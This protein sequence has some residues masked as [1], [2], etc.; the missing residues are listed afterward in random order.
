[1][2]FF[3]NWRV[4][5]ASCNAYTPTMEQHIAKLELEWTGADTLRR[6][7]IFE[8]YRYSTS[9]TQCPMFITTGML[10]NAM[11]QQS[12]ERWNELKVIDD[13]NTKHAILACSTKEAQ[14]KILEDFL[15]HK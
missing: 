1:M 7:K 12:C 9:K 6:N 5:L 8:E 14:D 3:D 4:Q 13:D 11:W 15:S 2:S 10:L